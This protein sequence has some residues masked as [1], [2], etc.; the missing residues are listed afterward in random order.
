M[1]P[2]L[3]LGVV[4]AP[5]QVGLQPGDGIPPQPV[6]VAPLVEVALQEVQ[7]QLLTSAT[8]GPNHVDVW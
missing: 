7:G 5:S 3:P 6:A 8:H 4:D 2:H 1:P